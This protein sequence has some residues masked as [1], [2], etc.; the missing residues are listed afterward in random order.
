MVESTHKRRS[1]G[2][3]GLALL[4]SNCKNRIE[5]AEA[6]EQALFPKGSEQQLLHL[7]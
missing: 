7:Q 3:G 1:P 2:G 6:F 5:V 4:S